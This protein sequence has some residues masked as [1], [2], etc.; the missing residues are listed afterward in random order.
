MKRLVCIMLCVS[1]L[2]GMSGCSSAPVLDGATLVTF[3]DSITA[4][5]TWPQDV[6]EKLNMKLVN[7]G[8]GGHTTDHAAARL[9]RDVLSRDP[10]F[11]IISF[12]SNDFYRPAGTPQ[13]AL[14]VYKQNL[15][16]FVSQ[17]KGAGAVP[18]LMTPPFISEG[19]SGGPT[20]Y[21]EGTVNAALDTY[22]D[23]MR[24]VASE[25]KCD[26]IDI[27]DMC[28]NGQTVQTFL[29]ADGV[30][31]S[32]LGNQMYARTIVDYMTAHFEID[33]DAAR[34]EQP[35]VPEA[36]KAPFTQSLIPFDESEWLEVFPDTLTIEGGEHSIAF[37][38]KTGQWP[39][40]HYSPS[41]SDAIVV[42]L[43]GSY[44]TIDIELIAATN[45]LLFFNG[46]TPTRTYSDEYF[47]LTRPLMENI[48]NLRT[49]GDDILEG[50]TIK[51]T[52]PL[53]E[54]I[55]PALLQEDGTVVFS[56]VKVF[57]IGG[58]GRTVTINEL[59]VTSENV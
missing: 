21:P 25:Q 53:D 45:I 55:T 4:L 7:S 6:A 19:A 56:G 20:L 10:D 31:L 48:P 15:T 3:G 27:H 22:V 40:A 34:V 35:T 49:S 52:I 46:N 39:E 26:L 23:A 58:A 57:A 17:I 36:L 16:D 9:E 42:P 32:T 33:P 54:L 2:L 28:D 51:C 5:S 18:I 29:I 14:D 24:E 11:V 41:L 50:Q 8:I 59:S 30:H 37:A 47:S 12:G 43:E 38:N 1:T 13:V 44:L